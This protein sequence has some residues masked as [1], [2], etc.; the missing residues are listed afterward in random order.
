[1]VGQNLYRIIICIILASISSCK[2][3]SELESLRDSGIFKRKS[4]SLNT[5]LQEVTNI[6]LIDI[7]SSSWI[8]QSNQKRQ[9]ISIRFLLF[10]D[11]IAQLDTLEL[12]INRAMSFSNYNKPLEATQLNT[13][14]SDYIGDFY[15]IHIK[16]NNLI[17]RQLL[18]ANTDSL[19]IDFLSS[20]RIE[21]TLIFDGVIIRIFG[22]Y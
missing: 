7:N 20:E 4:E 2:N 8:Y 11:S 15:S 17:N 18:T 22:D 10:T 16:N 1:M 21:G 5:S 6:S 9:R 19:F 12:A 3:S 13:F 14:D